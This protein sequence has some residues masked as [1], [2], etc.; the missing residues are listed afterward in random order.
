MKVLANRKEIDTE[1]CR[2]ICQYDKYY[3]AVAWASTQ[4]TACDLLK[5][6]ADR[7]GKMIVGT[8]F[9]QTHPDFIATF[10]RHRRVRFVLHP[11]GIFHPKLYLF[12]STK[13]N[14]ECIIGSPNFT[15]AALSQNVE[16]AILITDS[17]IGADSEHRK[18]RKQIEEYWRQS[19]VFKKPDFAIYKNM[20]KQKQ[21]S[22]RSLAGHQYKRRNLGRHSP[23]KSDLVQY[24][25]KAF[26]NLVTQEKLVGIP[27]AL[28]ERICVL[29]KARELFQRTPKFCDLSEID[30]KIVAGFMTESD[31]HWRLF[32]STQ[33]VGSFMRA[34]I[35]Y[36]EAIS[37]AL[38][39]IPL[40]DAVHRSDYMRFMKRMQKALPTGRCNLGTVTRLLAMKRPDYF[41]CLNGKNRGKLCEALG[42]P[43][44]TS[45]DDYWNLIIEPITASL[46][47]NSKE[48]RAKTEREVWQGRC[49]F[50]DALF[51]S[52]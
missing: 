27:D 51:Y 48:P 39:A 22:I 49:A 24:T 44:K 2:L 26:Y 3:W 14:W 21:A 18:L 10:R 23:L 41:V 52:P 40:N 29:K 36:E 20:W 33:A 35:K 28:N 9:W 17:D 31:I 15:H 37:E 46:W 16:A 19:Q 30:R 42:I 32:G 5:T 12:E 43:R 11:G 6:H 13:G 25:W 8:H 50:L 47:W 1:I 45:I 7:I 4:S 34:I 38:D